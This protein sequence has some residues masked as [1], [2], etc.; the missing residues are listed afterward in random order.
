MKNV[1]YTTIAV[2]I[3]VFI[4]LSAGAFVHG[5]EGQTRTDARAREYGGSLD[6]RQHGYEHAYR[7][8]ADRGR[9]DRERRNAYSLRDNDYLSGARGYESAFG[10]RSQYMQGYR[11]GYKAGYDDGFNGRGGQYGQ[12]Y[13]R[14]P[15]S[16][17]AP[18]DDVY[19]ARP[20]SST[21][22]A[23]DAG[24]R[25]GIT[26][27]QQDYARNARSNFRNNDSYRN[28]DLG[29]RP[30]YGDRAAYRL[31]FRDG[32]ER[33]YEDGYGRSQ[34]SSGDPGR[35]SSSRG[36]TDSGSA[37]NAQQTTG[38]GG[39]NVQQAAGGTFTVPAN[40][41]WT[42]TGIRVNQGE[43]LRFTSTGEI[44]FTGDANDRS[45][46]AGSLAHKLVSGAPLPA[47]LAGALIGRIDNGL[48]FGIGDQA[49]ITIP[50]SGLLYLGTNDDNVSDNSGQ[51]QV[52]I[53][54]SR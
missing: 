8:G 41:Q 13:G 35:P 51:F 48:P 39:R 18:V 49:S 6:A 54:S 23:F 36:R 37:R 7:D 16:N 4:G 24:Y 15:G 5:A 33:G 43:V 50:A 12:L 42:P 28:A 32:M 31:Q 22:M 52:V 1:K 45:S 20:Y 9:Q 46:V 34:N 47:A 25:G 27:G 38:T 11:D 17:R 44:R 21:D 19:A 53:T 30:S 14:P 29:Y 10:D 2:A 40:R 3:T 26:L